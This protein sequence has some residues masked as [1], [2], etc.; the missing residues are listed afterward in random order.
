M[1]RMTFSTFLMALKYFPSFSMLKA[2][3]KAKSKTGNP[4]P[5]E[6]TI[7]MASPA[8]ADKVNGINIPK[9]NAPLYGQK[10][11]ANNAPNKNEPNNPLSLNFSVNLS[12]KFPIESQLNLITSSFSRL[13]FSV[14]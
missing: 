4:V 7:G 11:K 6:N 5:K 9:Y 8:L 10:V 1:N 3:I 2:M 14:F 13:F 12:V